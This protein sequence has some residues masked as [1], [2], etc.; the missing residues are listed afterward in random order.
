MI[1]VPM[2]SITTIRGCLHPL[3]EF[4]EFPFASW[5]KQKE[6]KV[7]SQ[8]SS[9]IKTKPQVALCRPA[10]FRHH[11]YCLVGMSTTLICVCG[12]V[13]WPHWQVLVTPWPSA[14]LSRASQ[15]GSLHKFL[16]QRVNPW[17]TIISWH[18]GVV[19]AGTASFRA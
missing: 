13:F 10:I 4:D 15:L 3:D 6:R 5:P 8:F 7:I 2:L 18:T 14:G 17:L 9:L 1:L 11:L 16:V 19:Q 12:L